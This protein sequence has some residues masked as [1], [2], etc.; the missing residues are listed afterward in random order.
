MGFLPNSFVGVESEIVEA[1]GAKREALLHAGASKLYDCVKDTTR[2]PPLPDA[3]LDSPHRFPVSQSFNA[4]IWIFRRKFSEKLGLERL[5][6]WSAGSGLSPEPRT[7][8]MEG[9]EEVAG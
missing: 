6:L 3:L 9:P 8:P 7:A 1:S 5:S 2:R 4:G